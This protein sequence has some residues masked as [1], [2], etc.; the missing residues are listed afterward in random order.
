MERYEFYTSKVLFN[1]K[2][3]TL[4]RDLP[5]LTIQRSVS[6]AQ[7]N[8][9]STCYHKGEALWHAQQWPPASIL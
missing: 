6:D 4:K 3:H 5:S 8:T 1:R 9:M 7:H 2:G